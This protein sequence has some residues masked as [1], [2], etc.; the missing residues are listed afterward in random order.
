MEKEQQRVAVVDPE[1]RI[2]FLV[3]RWLLLLLQQ[4]LLLLLLLL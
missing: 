2:S 4:L 1:T 3:A